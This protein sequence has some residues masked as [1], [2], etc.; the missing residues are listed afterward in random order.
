MEI[1]NCSTATIFQGG[2]PRMKR[3]SNLYSRKFLQGWRRKMVLKRAVFSMQTI[4]QQLIA[5]LELLKC[6]QNGSL[7]IQ[8]TFWAHTMYNR[9]EHLR[10]KGSAFQTTG[11]YGRIV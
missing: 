10:E 1:K 11:R 8:A 5:F 4:L 7:W 6:M 2:M 3:I 9:K